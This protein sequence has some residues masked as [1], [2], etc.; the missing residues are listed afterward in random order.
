MDHCEARQRELG[1]LKVDDLYKV[2]T[3]CLTYDCLTGEAPAELCSMFRQNDEELRTT[4]RSITNKPLDIKLCNQSR[5][6]SSVM[7]SSFL[8]KTPELW[9]QLPESIQ[10]SHNKAVLQAKLKKHFLDQYATVSPC[11]N[12][13][14]SNLESCYHIPRQ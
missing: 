8:L 1:I 14:C 12:A 9:N 11:T 2:Q 13:L 5:K 3:I 10:L 6:A 4:T 7:N